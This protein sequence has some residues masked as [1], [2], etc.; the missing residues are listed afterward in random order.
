MTRTPPVVLTIAGTDSGGGAGVAADLATF[1]A[2]GVHGA[3]AVAVVTAQDTTAVRLLHRLPVDVLRAQIRAVL[4]DLPVAVVKTGLLGSVA[5][6]EAVA[7][8][9]A[10]L[11]LV[12]DPVLRA[13]TGTAFADDE[14]VRSYRDTLL[15]LATVV[16]PNAAEAESLG[17]LS[18][19]VLRTGS[20]TGVDL[21]LQPGAPPVRLPHDPIDTTNDHGT[22]CTHSAALAAYLALGHDLPPAAALAATFTATRLHDAIDWD[23]GRGRGPIAHTI[24]RNHA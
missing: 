2:I 15:P 11:P 5:A 12:V 6:I 24:G 21:L 14:V 8:L 22:G 3:C 17:P 13:S 10:G 18:V 16:T 19:P 4:E 1:A 20:E 23:L 7:E 9:V